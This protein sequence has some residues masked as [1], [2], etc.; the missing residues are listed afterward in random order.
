M[1][2]LH[3]DMARSRTAGA[4]NARVGISGWQYAPWRGRFYPPKLPQRLELAYASRRFNALEINGTF[5]SLQRPGN[6]RAWHAATPAGFVFA[7]KGGRYLTHFRKLREPRE[8]LANFFASGVLCLREKLG[9]IL[10]QFPPFLSFDRDNFAAFFDLLPESTRQLARLAR[11][12]SAFLKGRTWL[13]ADVDRPVRHAVEV[14]HDSFRDDRFLDLLRRRNFA[15]VIADTAG[16]FPMFD[17]VT[18]DWLYV[19]LHGS[20]KLYSSGYGP[21]EIRAWANKIRGWVRAARVEWEGARGERKTASGGTRTLRRET[22]SAREDRVRPHSTIVGRSASAR[23]VSHDD[24]PTMAPAPLANA[25][26]FFDNTDE[27]LRAP[28][29]ARRMAAELGA[30]MPGTPRKVLAELLRR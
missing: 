28:V 9:P 6:F 26:V 16:R 29:D 4:V 24:G 22:G 30:E 8:P 23:G 25:Y 27:K 5:Y 10:W 2:A 13:E 11:G 20:R 21:A 3:L 17:A 19:R 1:S 14:R 7:L 15:L 18:A 12:H